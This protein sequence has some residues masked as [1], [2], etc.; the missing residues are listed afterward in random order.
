[1]LAIFD[2]IQDLAKFNAKPHLFTYSAPFGGE[3]A[4]YVT[5]ESGCEEMFT[6][7]VEQFGGTVM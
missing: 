2:S 5:L 3:S 1:M 7:R 4:F 6:A